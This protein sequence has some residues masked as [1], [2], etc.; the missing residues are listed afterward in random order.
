MRDRKRG[1]S[2]AVRHLSRPC[3]RR[4]WVEVWWVVEARWW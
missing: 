3:W 4:A 1:G 2:E